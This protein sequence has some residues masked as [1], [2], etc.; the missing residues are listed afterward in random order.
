MEKKQMYNPENSTTKEKP[1]H[2][3][4]MISLSFSSSLEKGKEAFTAPISQGA[5][6]QLTC[7]PDD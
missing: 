1:S 4:K 2:S 7:G 5:Q 6:S 3:L